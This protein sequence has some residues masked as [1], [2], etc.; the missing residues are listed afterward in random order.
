MKEMLMFDLVFLMV[1][2]AFAAVITSVVPMI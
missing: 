1:L 2:L